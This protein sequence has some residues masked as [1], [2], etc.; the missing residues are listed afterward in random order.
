MTSKSEPRQR[1]GLSRGLTRLAE[2][3]IAE[4]PEFVPLKPGEV[5]PPEYYIGKNAA[6][7]LRRVRKHRRPIRSSHFN[8]IVFV[9]RVAGDIRGLFSNMR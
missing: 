5:R 4:D 9:R 8:I 1:P 7:I 3:L 6:K 2:R